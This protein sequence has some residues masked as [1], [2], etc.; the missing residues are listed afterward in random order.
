MSTTTSTNVAYGGAAARPRVGLLNRF[1]PSSL[2]FIGMSLVLVVLIVLPLTALIVKSFT[3]P[4]TGG[5]TIA[6]YIDAYGKTRHVQ[7]LVNTLYM[8]VAVVILSL[9]F[10]LPLAWG[11]SRT[12]MPFK[13]FIRAGVRTDRI[14]DY[15]KRLRNPEQKHQQI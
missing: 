14:Q 10:A 5:F 2:V 4:A 1:Q 8:G 13:P 12:D 7:A 6:N 15:G 3:D 11:C 9:I